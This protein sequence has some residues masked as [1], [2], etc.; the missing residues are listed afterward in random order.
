MRIVGS[1]APARV[2]TLSAPRRAATGFS[3][4]EE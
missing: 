2:N 3:V 4:A 1:N